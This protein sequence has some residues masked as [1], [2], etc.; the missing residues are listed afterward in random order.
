MI[1]HK[2]ST[3]SRIILTWA[4]F[5][6]FMFGQIG[7]WTSKVQI[8]QNMPKCFKETYPCTGVIL[9]C[10]EIKVQT[11]SSKGFEFRNLLI[12][13]IAHNI[14]SQRPGRHSNPPGGYFLV[15]D[16]WGCAAGWGRIFASGLIIMGLHF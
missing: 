14:Q 5:L 12:I 15:K 1:Q 3:V 10:T 7:I 11:P 8:D 6:Y 13:Q 4:N 2:L 16:Y 9:D